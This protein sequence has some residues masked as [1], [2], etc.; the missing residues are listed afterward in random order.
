MSTLLGELNDIDGRGADI[1]R[2][3]Q[4]LFGFSSFNGKQEEVIRQVMSG[5][6]TI[7]VMPTGAGKSLC[8]QLPA[9]LL[10]GLT[11]VISPLI[12]LMKD[13]YDSLPA[14][15]Y[16]RTTFINST[17]DVEELAQRMQEIFAGKYK[18]VYCAPER[19]RQQSFV[20]ALRRARISLLVIDEAHC[21]SMWGHDFRP[22]YLFIGP[23]LKQLGEPQLL[24]LTATATPQMRQE[25]AAQL[26]RDLEPVV[27]SVFRA[28][29]YYEVEVLDDKEA[30]MRRLVEICKAEAGAGVVYA[31]SR[32]T[33][34]QLAAMLKRERV[35]AAY[36]HAGMP[37]E[38]RSRT[39][40]N[41]MLDRVRV[42]VATIAF[43]MGVDKSNVRFIVHFSP[44]GT[45]EGYVQESG[46]AG[47]DGRPSRCVL[48]VTSGD[49]ANLSRWKK[50]EQLS[51]DELRAVYREITQQVPAGRTEFINL[52]AIERQ[53][54]AVS[55]K[56]IDSTGVRVCLSL[57]ERVRLIVRHPDS[58]R[59]VTLRLR[60]GAASS[61]PLL[62]RLAEVAGIDSTQPVRCDLS[63]LSRGLD[64]TP[65]EL[66]RSLLQWAE[67]GLLQFRGD[68]RDPVVQRLKPP[69]DTR[70]AMDDLLKKRD[71]AQQRQ[72]D[73]IFYYAEANK[74]RHKLLASHLGEAIE[75]CDSSCDYCAPPADRP[76]QESIEAPD[77]PSNPGQVIVECLA[78]FPFHAGKPSLAKA[79]TGSATSNMNATKVKHFGALAA[80]SGSAIEKAVDEL[81]KD[82]YIEFYEEDGYK[83][84][85]PTQDGLDGVPRGAISLGAKRKKQSARK[86]RSAGPSRHEAQP[87]RKSM[88]QL[89]PNA[90]RAILQRGENSE[91]P[92]TA[93]EADL[94]ERL[95]AWRRVKA[96]AANLPPYVI[97]HDKT[98]WAMARARPRS[99]EEMLVLKGVGNN[100]V[101]KYGTELLEL[102]NS[103]PSLPDD[104]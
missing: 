99:P 73:Q 49:K 72:L 41:F 86:E 74:C 75:E 24:A 31:R 98:L 19:L 55:G 71:E 63:A 29:L 43:G 52:E 100:A 79:L 23:T 39:Q 51:K 2:E 83:L 76:K 104:E 47:R 81:V 85:R 3:L 84:I 37:P 45:L 48:L 64:T 68:R 9:M 91:E 8:Y 65:T 44:P 26:G 77:L 5:V 96:N 92:P 82:G 88:S 57:L 78:S 4:R 61:D 80:A 17:L 95:R 102:L 34:E 67:Q 32:E 50:Q 58:P 18:L 1:H 56:Q 20:A 87:Q 59:T 90:V 7:A 25:I 22:D 11:L 38:E 46:R 40:E 97:F 94:F 15:V 10:P 103:E 14:E 54:Q 36:Y 53:T 6:D 101:E 70:G 21:V 12:A 89:D 30:K 27:A 13:Q 35:Q 16:G 93:E 33:C 66:E 60:A 62:G 69:D 28:N 42:M